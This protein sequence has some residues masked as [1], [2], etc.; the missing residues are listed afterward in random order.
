[1]FIASANPRFPPLNVKFDQS[2]V[3][4]FRD[5]RKHALNHYV[6]IN[7]ENILFILASSPDLCLNRPEISSKYRL[8]NKEKTGGSICFQ[9]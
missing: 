3:D 4:V 2:F 9:L 6:D 8:G 7:L 1:M 5:L